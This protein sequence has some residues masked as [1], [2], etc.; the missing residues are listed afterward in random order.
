MDHKNR[1]IFPGIGR[2]KFFYLNFISAKLSYSK[3]KVSFAAVEIEHQNRA[4]GI[5]AALKSQD[6]SK[7]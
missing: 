6:F 7:H 3:R 2:A 4:I 5:R 1:M